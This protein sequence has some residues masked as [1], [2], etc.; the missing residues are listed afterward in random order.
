MWRFDILDH[1]PLP[2]NT[3]DA[4]TEG[5]TLVS[6]LGFEVYA[7]RSPPMAEIEVTMTIDPRGAR[8]TEFLIVAPKNFNF[9]EDCLTKG[10]LDDEIWQCFKTDPVA[11]RQAA[12]LKVR[13]PM[14]L[15]VPLTGLI[16]KV[17]M[18]DRPQAEL[19]WYM[20]ARSAELDAELGWAEDAKG[21]QVRPIPHSGVVYT[22][23]AKVEG[24]LVVYFQSTIRIDIGGK[25]RIGYPP[26]A[27]VNCNQAEGMFQR[28]SIK[29]QATCLDHPNHF[30]F[31]ITLDYPL[32]PGRQA[33]SVIGMM[34]PVFFGGNNFTLLAYEPPGPKGGKVIDGI[35][36][37]PGLRANKKI[38]VTAL[39]MKFQGTQA[40]SLSRVSLGFDM[41]QALPKEGGPVISEIVINVPVEFRHQVTHFNQ[42]AIYSPFSLPYLKDVTAKEE[43]R[44]PDKNFAFD[45]PNT[46]LFRIKFDVDFKKPQFFAGEHRFEFSV[47]IPAVMPPMNVWTLTICEPGLPKNSVLANTTCDN[48]HSERAVTTFPWAGFRMGQASSGILGIASGAVRCFGFQG[49]WMVLPFIC[50]FVTVLE[51]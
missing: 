10:G 11:D 34:P 13:N 3:N 40:L 32:S 44:Y 23:N 1:D 31:E 29:G 6:P 49:F 38:N 24:Q 4:L 18:P 20:Q 12:V 16:I 45:S 39:P 46:R 19:S 50:M 43:G 37:I 21:I 30:F 26:G 17:I 47:M 35:M 27:K 33:F 36:T 41:T 51:Q 5:F 14:G 22:G 25:L 42:V 9:T 7:A 28:I 2:V 48:E 15:L 8:P